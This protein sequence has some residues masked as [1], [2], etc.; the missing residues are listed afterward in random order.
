MIK[1][2][3][4]ENWPVHGNKHF[5]F[6][7]GII[8][9]QGPNESGK[10]L[11][12]EAIGFCLHGSSALRRPAKDY[13]G[14]QSNMLFVVNG[15]TY[16]LERGLSKALLTGP[17]DL[18]V[19]GTTPVNQHVE[20]LFGYSSKVFNVANM[21]R[22]DDIQRLALMSSAE[23]KSTINNL[24]GLEPVEKTIKVYKEILTGL[25]S[26]LKG[27]KQVEPE[28][29]DPVDAPDLVRMETLKKVI[30]AHSRLK[31]L[32][33]D[34]PDVVEKPVVG[35]AE[36]TG[37]VEKTS[38]LKQAAMQVRS[39]IQQAELAR[40]VPAPSIPLPE[41]EQQW[42]SF[43][44]YVDN[45]ALKAKGTTT[46]DNCQ[47][48]QFLHPNALADLPPVKQPIISLSAAY[49]LE[50]AYSTACTKLAELES[51]HA[52]LEKLSVQLNDLMNELES[53]GDVPKHWAHYW[54][55]E[56]ASQ[57]YDQ[58]VQSHNQLA[59]F[60]SSMTA[61]QAAR[62]LEQLEVQKL[63]HNLFCMYQ[64]NAARWQQSVDNTEQAIDK[65]ET[66]VK[67][68]VLLH[69]T[70][71]SN[72]LPSLNAM[73]SQLLDQMTDGKHPQ[74]ELAETMDILVD[75]ETIDALSGSG[76]AV[77]HLALRLSLGSILTS[78]MFPVALFDEIDAG[79]D[80]KR[81]GNVMSVL[82]SMLDRF[83]QVF[84]ISHKTLENVNQTVNL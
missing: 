77:A 53:L 58:Y 41:L 6:Q 84:V 46:C 69:G 7:E 20:R 80:V 54:H 29:R 61:E 60:T 21:C 25:R 11:L 23:R 24:I 78:R 12:F 4:I 83:Q 70:I 56:K 32:E 22:Q 3:T 9:I 50:Q 2:L 28:K 40:L 35:Q 76:R 33:V 55:Y 81:S 44:A 48:V 57:A 26:E 66:I 42:A 51:L 82:G 75:D 74:L 17:D 68:L 8:A 59:V 18:N 38:A 10:S 47:H 34:R 79:M 43:R 64:S 19:S 13:K 14:I 27:I 45:E 31:G 72:I 36:Y 65:N 62:E 37:L 15:Q 67:G 39:K 5:D 16:K 30:T 63:H 73:A 52:Q 71:K 49:Q 1:S